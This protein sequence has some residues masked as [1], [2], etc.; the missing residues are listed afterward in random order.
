MPHQTSSIHPPNGFD[1]KHRHP[2]FSKHNLITLTSHFQANRRPDIADAVL[3][4]ITINSHPALKLSRPF[5]FNI[6][7]SPTLTQQS[8]TISLP[9][10]HSSI[11]IKPYVPVAQTQRPWRL[12]VTVNNTRISE[13]YQPPTLTQQPSSSNSGGSPEKQQQPPQQQQPREK[14]H[15]LFEARL[16]PGIN[17]IDV[18]VIAG[19]APMQVRGQPVPKERDSVEME[20]CTV[21]VNLMKAG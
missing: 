5:R 4:N 17:R 10:T 9:G 12:F 16:Q 19:T 14:G 18:E 20:K 7:A 1:N 2:G 15:P 21:F 6:P 8:I 11:Q 3:P 13:V